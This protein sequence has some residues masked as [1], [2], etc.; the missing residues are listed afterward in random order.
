M[1]ELVHFL[2]GRHADRCLIALSLIT[3]KCQGCMF[4]HWGLCRLRGRSV[5]S[6]SEARAGRKLTDGASP[7]Q[8]GLELW[9]HASSLRLD[10]CDTPTVGKAGVV[11]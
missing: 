9:R 8:I 5:G 7:A 1:I 2:L 3:T 6:P 11:F 4:A 10:R